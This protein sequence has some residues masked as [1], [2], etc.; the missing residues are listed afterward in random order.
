VNVFRHDNIRPQIE[1]VPF[2]GHGNCVCEV[3]SRPIPREERLP[4]ETG[5]RQAMGIP[6]PVPAAAK[7]PISAVNKHVF[8][9]YLGPRIEKNT[10]KQTTLVGGTVLF[11]CLQCASW[12]P[13]PP[14]R[15][16]EHPQ[17]S[18]DGARQTPC[19]FQSHQTEP[20]RHREQRPFSGG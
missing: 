5:E 6:G 17:T 4:A 13:G 1:L 15:E 11:P 9:L 20:Q 10:H 19:P 7:L 14:G 12:R 8:L 3:I 16:E 2:P 18:D